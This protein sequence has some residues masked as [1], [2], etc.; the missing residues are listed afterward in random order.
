MLQ[1]KKPAISAQ[2]RLE[3]AV[4]VTAASARLILAAFTACSP[5]Y[6]ERFAADRGV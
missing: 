2:G 1:R 5:G 3:R 6:G 4:L